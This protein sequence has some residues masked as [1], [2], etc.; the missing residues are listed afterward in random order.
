MDGEIKPWCVKTDK[1][2]LVYD[3]SLKTNCSQ[4]EFRDFAGVLLPDESIKIQWSS[5]NCK[6]NLAWSFFHYPQLLMILLTTM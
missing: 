6:R 1:I 5:P 3:F 4:A 2:I